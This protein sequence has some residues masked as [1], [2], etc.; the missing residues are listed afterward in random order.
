VVA[1]RRSK[2]AYIAFLE[3]ILTKEAYSQ[4]VGLLWLSEGECD[5]VITIVHE[6]N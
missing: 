6:G 3:G 1:Q 4:T 5:C 2:G